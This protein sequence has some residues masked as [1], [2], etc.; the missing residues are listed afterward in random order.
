MTLDAATIARQPIFDGEHRNIGYEFFFR[1]KDGECDL[2]NPRAATAAVLVSLLNQIGLRASA[3]SGLLFVNIDRSILQTD[4]LL[5]APADRFVFEVTAEAVLGNKEREM[6]HM[7]TNKGYMFALSNASSDASLFEAIQ[8]LLPF[9][10]Y[11][12]FDMMSTDIESVAEMIKDFKGKKLIAERIEFEE[13]FEA[14]KA[15]GFDLFQG[16][17]FGE[18]ETMR[19]NRIDPK[20]LGVLKIYNLLLAET[21]IDQVADEL[22]KHNELML[23][24]LQYINSTAMSDPYPNRSVKEILRKFSAEKLKSWL[25]M[26]I[27]SKSSHTIDVEKSELSKMVERRVDLMYTV[28]KMLH[29]PADEQAQMFEKARLTAFLSLME[30]VLNVCMDTLLEQIPSDPMIEEALLYNEGTMGAVL[31]LA[32]ATEEKN[33]ANAKLYRKRLHLTAESLSALEK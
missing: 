30:P 26:I 29:L 4:L 28:I 24:L 33:G 32:V 31:G 21:P 14:C 5:S 12:K 3:G 20:H 22:Q 13:M 16:F 27:Y 7:Y 8:S 18:L 1:N 2:S 6:L 9:F 19:H 11:V 17:L 25:L 10:E 15:I 23:Q